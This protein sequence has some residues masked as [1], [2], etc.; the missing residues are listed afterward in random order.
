MFFLKGALIISTG[1]QHC[2]FR[3]RACNNSSPCSDPYVTV[4]VGTN[5]RLQ[6]SPVVLPLPSESEFPLLC[7]MLAVLCILLTTCCAQIPDD[8]NPVFNWKAGPFTW[9]GFD[10]VEVRG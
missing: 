6:T 7:Q 4:S 1:F 2:S 5:N 9:N 8:L 3:L 10:A